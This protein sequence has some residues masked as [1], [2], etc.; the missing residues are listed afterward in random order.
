MTKTYLRYKQ[1]A[2]HGIIVSPHS[3]VATDGKLAFTAE[4]EHVGV[5]NVRRGVQVCHVTGNICQLTMVSLLSKLFCPLT[6]LR[7]LLLLISP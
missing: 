7:S 1:S 2:V 5:W 4:L 3:N 6:I